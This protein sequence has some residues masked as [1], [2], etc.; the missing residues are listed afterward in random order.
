M[1]PSENVLKYSLAFITKIQNIKPHYNIC[2]IF[3][4]EVFAMNYVLLNL[5]KH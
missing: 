2:I 5:F 3:S 1:S 4:L